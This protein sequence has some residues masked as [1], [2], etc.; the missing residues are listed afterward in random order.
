MGGHVDDLSNSVS[1]FGSG[2]V[3]SLRSNDDA[4]LGTAGRNRKVTRC[5]HAIAT[6]KASARLVWKTKILRHCFE[7]ILET[8]TRGA[9]LGSRLTSPSTC[10]QNVSKPICA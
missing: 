7:E 2:G 9:S 1:E 6:Q 3:K 8:P 5:T 4:R 10:D